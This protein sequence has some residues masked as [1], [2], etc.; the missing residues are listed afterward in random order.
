MNLIR[1]FRTWTLAVVLALL[2]GSAGA[3]VSYTAFG[4]PTAGRLAFAAQ[5]PPGAPAAPLVV[6][7]SGFTYQGRLQDGGAPA[8]G[9]YDFTF[10]LY[11]A[12]SGGNQINDPVI[13][14]AQ[15]VSDGLFTI[16]LDSGST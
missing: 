5:A 1:S 6:T 15:P 2:A 12:A 8:N 16:Y 3:G 4:L 11:D 14:L 9:A 10:T 13:S 7:G